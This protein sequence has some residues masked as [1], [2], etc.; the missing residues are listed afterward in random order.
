V[1]DVSSTKA[2]KAWD[3]GA[4]S[5]FDWMMVYNGAFPTAMSRYANFF[6]MQIFL[7]TM[8]GGRQVNL[9]HFITTM[10]FELLWP[11]RVLFCMCTA[12]R[13]SASG[14]CE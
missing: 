7:N 8:A 13:E 10:L 6:G 3:N 2:Y 9:Q 1:N 4:Y 14:A 11:N 12:V 5:E